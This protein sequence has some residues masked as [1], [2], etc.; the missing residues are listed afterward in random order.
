MS[1]R[2]AGDILGSEQAGFIDS[3]GIDLYMKMLNDEVLRLKGI[4][5]EEK[6]SSNDKSLVEVDTHIKDSY[7]DDEE[8]KI[9][10]HKLINTIDSIDKLNEIKK[11]L[12]DRFGKLDDSMLIYMNEELFENIIKKQGVLKV[13]ENNSYI[14]LE[15]TKEK[16]E[17]INYEDL[18]VLSIKICSNFKFSY[19][20]GR[21]YLKLEKKL[22]EKHPIFYLNDLL[23]KI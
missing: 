7:V 1:I 8:L 14:E 4:V 23:E 17:I 22:L 21:L 9:E 5:I 18:F 19:K 13:V 2:G 12:E 15:F 6:H 16:S 11:E 3:V 10:I 20:N